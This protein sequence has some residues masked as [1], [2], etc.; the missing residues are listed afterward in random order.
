MY[1]GS[2]T[3]YHNIKQIRREA[4][5]TCSLK[6]KNMWT[7]WNL[8]S[9]ILKMTKATTRIV[10]QWINQIYPRADASRSRVA[11]RNSLSTTTERTQNR[12]HTPVSASLV[13]KDHYVLIH[14][15]IEL[16]SGRKPHLFTCRPREPYLNVIFWG[17]QDSL[18]FTW[19]TVFPCECKHST[20]IT[21]YGSY[22]V[23]WK[24]Q[25]K[26]LPAV[27]INGYYLTV[28]DMLKQMTKLS[29]ILFWDACEVC[30]LAEADHEKFG[31]KKI[32]CSIFY[33]KM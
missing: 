25:D 26:S 8:R 19:S 30:S 22:D 5:C 21:V 10:C 31:H 27:A 2:E 24:F 29:A 20:G 33:L 13:R 9:D 6:G 18:I 4:N 16:F 7:K 1:V 3:K 12:G 15:A 28:L 17:P 11:W 32:N 14:W 23:E